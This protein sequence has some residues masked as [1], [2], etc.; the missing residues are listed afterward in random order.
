M[1]DMNFNKDPLASV[2]AILCCGVAG[3]PDDSKKPEADHI[4]S[5][6]P[7][8]IT[9]LT[10]E[11]KAPGANIVKL[12]NCCALVNRY[13]AKCKEAGSVLNNA[14]ARD[15]MAQLLD[16]PETAFAV[17]AWLGGEAIEFKWDGNDESWQD[18]ER[19][20]GLTPA[21]N[22]S[23]VKWRVKGKT[24]NPAPKYAR[25]HAEQIIEFI[26]SEGW[27]SRKLSGQWGKIDGPSF[28]ADREYRKAPR[29]TPEQKAKIMDWLSGTEYA[30]GDSGAATDVYG[31]LYHTDFCKKLKPKMRYR[32]ALMKGPGAPF[33][34]TY[35]LQQTADS[36]EKSPDFVRWL[37]PWQ[38]AEAS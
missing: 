28:Y 35:H 29:Y 30:I 2:V 37:T 9:Q 38:E 8:N 12:S 17:A 4:H 36:A 20:D 25:P 5:V 24:A 10:D 22:A 23:G 1:N 15:V 16:D 26:N 7:W 33:T 31:I 14:E 34:S 27:E 11:H 6:A 13:A 3:V 19:I 18:Y 21:F 32:V